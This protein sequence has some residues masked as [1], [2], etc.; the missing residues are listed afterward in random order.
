LTAERG[1]PDERGP[2]PERK[3]DDHLEPG[4]GGGSGNAV[5]RED[6]DSRVLPEKSPAGAATSAEGSSEG[7]PF[8]PAASAGLRDVAPSEPALLVGVEIDGARD[9]WSLEASL[10]ELEALAMSAG[11]LP[12]GRITQRL[13]SPNPSTLIG[14]GKVDELRAAAEELEV[15]VV[16]F[17]RELS[18]RQQRN[19]ERKLETKVIDRTALI[20]DVFAKHARTREG[21]LQ[22]ELAQYEYRLPRLTRMWTHLA[23][24]AGGRAG[25]VG[26][27]VGLRGPGE[28]QLEIDKREIG[29]RISFLEQQIER[30][31]AQRRLSRQR[32]R[33]SGLPVIAIVGYTNA[34]KSTLINALTGADVYAADQLFATLDPT[35]R[36]LD[37]GSAGT[38]LITDTVGFMQRLP[39][40]LVAAFRATLEEVLE[41][42]VLLHV[43]DATHRDAVD[44]AESVERVLGEL[45]LGSPPMVTAI[46]K[47]DLVLE[48]TGLP[49]TEA[50]LGTLKTMPEVE[51]LLDLYPDAYLISAA[52]PLGLNDL[53]AALGRELERNM[54]PV[55]L[56]V[57][58]ADGD[59]ASRVH[60]HGVV[61]DESFDERGTHLR[62]RVPLWLARSLSRYVALDVDESDSPPLEGPGPDRRERQAQ[63][64]PS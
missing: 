16:L 6:P 51:P 31:G 12:V 62:A 32:R 55:E 39:T 41:A 30:L 37:L 13:D 17:D 38:A 47:C 45:G 44:Q 7:I 27:G 33:D 20:L 50:S 19:L 28:T 24:Q 43:L 21:M 3:R 59:V 53:R 9:G 14:S 26:G 8:E 22:V 5:S 34:G 4:S 61:E 23:R 46:N 10:D 2:E 60:V 40:Q 18:P 58:Y 49:L 35:T 1:G 15:E 64:K 56:L 48:A 54:L 57:P 63:R 52:V 11:V 29:R 42:D 25:G 36:R